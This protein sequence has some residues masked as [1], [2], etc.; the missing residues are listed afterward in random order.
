MRT[1]R[2][3]RSVRGAGLRVPQRLVQVSSSDPPLCPNSSLIPS[4]ADPCG[5]G[6][7]FVSKVRYVEAFMFTLAKAASAV[8][9][10]KLDFAWV[11]AATL[12]AALQHAGRTKRKNVVVIR[13]GT[14]CAACSPCFCPDLLGCLSASE[15]RCCDWLLWQGGA[16][17]GCCFRIRL[18]W[19]V[20]GSSACSTNW[21]SH[22][23]REILP[24][25]SQPCSK[26]RP[27]I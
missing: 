5:Y 24:P 18:A 16:C 7:M 20:A 3:A 4:L 26:L 9:T 21:P 19:Q 1:L 27:P 13:T 17:D 10:E 11:P 6:R 2:A 23:G 15:H 8:P 25:W 22:F 14:R 12:L